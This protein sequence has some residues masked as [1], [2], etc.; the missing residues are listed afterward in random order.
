MTD[1]HV[2]AGK[3]WLAYNAAENSRDIPAMLS[4]V[5]TYLSVTVNGH[6]AVSSASDDERAMRVIFETYPDYR[7][8]V[9]EVLEI[10]GGKSA[11][12]L[13]RMRGTSPFATAPELDVAGCSVVR[14]HAGVLTH[15]QLFYQAP[16]LDEL[17]RRADARS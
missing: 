6:P 9:V 1:Y 16:V 7:R 12:A 14:A 15:A 5:A 2:T 11:V 17:L 13:W 4:L 3:V 8:E 10:D